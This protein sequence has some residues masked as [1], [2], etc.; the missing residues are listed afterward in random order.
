MNELEF[1]Y[2]ITLDGWL[3]ALELKDANTGGHTIRVTE[4]SLALARFL[5]IQGDE[6]IQLR[7]GAILHDIGKIGVPDALLNKPDPLTEAEWTL[8]RLHP[9][10]GYGMLAPISFLHPAAD[11]VY[12]HHENW[13]G[14]GYPRGLKGDEIPLMARIVSVC[15][16]WD[17]LVSDQP[18][19]KALSWEAALNNIEQGSGM[20]FDPEIVDAFMRFI[21]DKK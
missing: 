2:D 5:G 20:Q 12:C 3:R 17:S 9:E 10:L 7:R 15:N 19:R 16:M 13:D 11:V 8:M 1:A 4:L 6:L 18:Y 21:K 14:S